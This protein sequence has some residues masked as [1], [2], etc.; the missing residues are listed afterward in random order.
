M[1]QLIRF[2]IFLSLFWIGVLHPHIH[3]V[4]LDSAQIFLNQVQNE[5]YGNI[6]AWEGVKKET[7]EYSQELQVK[8]LIFVPVCGI[9]IFFGSGVCVYCVEVLKKGDREETKEQD[10]KI[11]D[12]KEED[13]RRNCA[14]DETV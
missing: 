10:Q 4:L 5:D 14:L 3:V 13:T 11:R 9:F 7:E 2:C 1:S 12:R 6:V 8:G